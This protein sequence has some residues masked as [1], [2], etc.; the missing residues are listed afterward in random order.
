L[1]G[2]AAA[3]GLKD[4]AAQAAKLLRSAESERSWIVLRQAV[5]EF[6]RDAQPESQSEAA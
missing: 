5:A 3:A 2:K 1:L 4:V 6:T